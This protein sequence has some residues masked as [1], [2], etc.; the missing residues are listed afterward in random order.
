[1]N[2]LVVSNFYPPHHVGGYELGCHDV[3]QALAG[4]GHRVSVLTSTHGVARSTSED[5]VHRR[6]SV[7]LAAAPRSAPAYVASLVAAEARG[8]RAFLRVVAETRPDLVYV[9]NLRYLPLSIARLAGR[10]GLPVC[11]FVSDDWLARW[12]TTDR[13]EQWAG[14]TPRRRAARVLKRGLRRAVEVLWPAGRG[15]A[16]DLRH[17]QFASHYLRQAC[18]EAGQPV[19]DASVVHWGVDVRR[20]ARREDDP[21]RTPGRRPRLLYAG[22]LVPHK[23]PHTAI[24]ACRLLVHEHAL[25]GVELTIAG[26]SVHPDYR[27]RLQASVGEAGLDGRV[28]FTGALDRAAMPALY[29][30]H[31][32]LIFPSV[33]AE[34]FSLTLLEAMASGLAVVGTITGGT[35]E[36]VRHDVNA[37]VFAPEDAAACARHVRTLVERPE[38]RARLSRQARRTVETDFELER[39]VDAIERRLRSA[40]A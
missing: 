32:V 31:D 25:A 35:G 34:P 19:A 30:D 14:G 9:W 2:L 4:R 11:Y 38:V 18:L 12:E 22:Q 15:E 8:R 6:L 10:L 39:M 3:V 16:L 27:R 37:L 17:A 20:F 1:V 28:R 5:G 40:A 29:R 36:L 26:G 21:G 13:W 7:D 33:W 24:E 23:G